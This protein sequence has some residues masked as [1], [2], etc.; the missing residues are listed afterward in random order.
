MLKALEQIY[1]PRKKKKYSVAH[2]STFRL[3]V[4]SKPGV[5]WTYGVW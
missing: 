2:Y 1:A 5:S 3:G 4:H